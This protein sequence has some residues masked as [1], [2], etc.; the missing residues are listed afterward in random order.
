MSI[1]QTADQEYKL[2]NN[3]NQSIR[4]QDAL[5]FA[6]MTFITVIRNATVHLKN[7][8]PKTDSDLETTIM[9]GCFKLKDCLDQAKIDATDVDKISSLNGQLQFHESKKG[10]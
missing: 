10:R 3:C 4:K 6:M 7:A 9:N 1:A 2:I 8:T 5:T